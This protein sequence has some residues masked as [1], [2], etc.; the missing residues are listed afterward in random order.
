M[1]L[2]PSRP[3]LPPPVFHRHDRASFAWRTDN[4]FY[5]DVSDCPCA[6]SGGWRRSSLPRDGSAWVKPVGSLTVIQPA[7]KAAG[8]RT[9]IAG[10]LMCVAGCSSSYRE[11]PLGLF[12]A[13]PDRACR[14]HFRSQLA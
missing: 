5:R 8:M 14:A 1:R 4:R 3:A 11:R 10:L 9:L 13:R 2:Q 6:R 7:M 12:E